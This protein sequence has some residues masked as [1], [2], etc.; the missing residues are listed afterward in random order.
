MRLAGVPLSQPVAGIAMGQIQDG[1]KTAILSDI[2]GSEDHTGDMDFKVAG[3][4][5]G[6]TA[7]QMDIKVKGVTRDLLERALRQARDGR[8][9]IL[10]TM[11]AAVPA[12]KAAVSEYAPRMEGI[13]IASERIGFLIGPGGK[14]IKGLQEQFKVKIAILNDNGEVSVAGL[15]RRLVDDCIRTIQA[16]TEMPKVGSRYRGTVKSTKDF[17]AF[18][19]ILPGTEGMCH[20]SELAEGYVDRVEDVVAVGDEIEVVVINVDDR[21]KIKLSHRQ[22]LAQA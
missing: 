11:L 1:D 4:G 8:I 2:L 6:I 10:K 18:I 13:R 3:S 5:L 21:G 16:M 9:H 14:T 20:I 12:P 19:E 15:D 7:L 22:A 17:G